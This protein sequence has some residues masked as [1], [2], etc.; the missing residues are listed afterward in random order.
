MVSRCGGSILTKPAVRLILNEAIIERVHHDVKNNVDVEIGGRWIGHVYYPGEQPKESNFEV[1]EDQMTYVIYGYLPTGPNPER[2]TA[3]ELMPDR[4]Y[5]LWTIKKIQSVNEDMEVLG[6]WHS[7]VP[8]GL[9]EYSQTDF[10]SYHSKLNN[11]DYPYPYDGLVCS[12][13]HTLPQSVE[14]T[15]QRLE[16]AW[17][18]VDGAYGQHSWYSENSLTWAP[19]SFAGEEYIPLGDYSAYLESTGHREISLDDWIAAIDYTA[20]STGYDSHVIKKSPSGE[21]LLLLESLPNGTDYAVEINVEGDA[22]FL[23]K[24]EQGKTRTN[25]NSVED[26]MQELEQHVERVT[27]LSARWSHVNRTLVLSQ[28]R[29]VTLD[30]ESLS[31]FKLRLARWFGLLNS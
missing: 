11:P 20:K 4:N 8:N 15:R 3:V 9:E 31:P 1:S 19:L 22:S 16:H 23:V 13:I 30:L 25:C 21:K 12:L 7:H 26:A 28:A 6:S 14:E 17:F 29:G 18:P 27:G 2:S 24:N 10:H 5:Q